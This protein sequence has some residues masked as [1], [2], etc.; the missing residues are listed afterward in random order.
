MRSLAILNQKGGVGKTTTA[1]NLSAAL[2]R[3][4]KHVLLLD[5]D[6]QAHASLHVGVQLAEGSPGLYEVLMGRMSLAEVVHTISP[7]LTLAPAGLDLVAA[8]ME[9]A[10]RD[11]RER[12]LATALGPFQSAFDFLIFDC[13]PSLGLLTVN[14][15]AAA[16]EVM[17]PLQPHF[18]ALQGLGRLLETVAAIQAEV[19]PSL[20]VSGIV[21]CMDEPTT[22]LAQEVRSDVSAFLAGSAPSDPWHGARVFE[23]TIRRNIKLAECPSF[24]KTIYDYAPDSRGAQD[25]ASLA[26]EVLAQQSASNARSAGSSEAAADAPKP[27]ARAVRTASAEITSS[28]TP[29]VAARA[30]RDSAVG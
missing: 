10:P 20:R 15:L 19:S 25:Y 28:E 18:F 2:A 8:E 24:G 30:R 13:S 1:V 23:S 21:L 27:H 29:A 16:Q 22:R 7:R 9:L 17:I 4:G 11:G 26:R 3:A 12:A 5:L 14:A 6:P